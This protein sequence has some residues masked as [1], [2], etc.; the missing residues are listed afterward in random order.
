M[1]IPRDLGAR[2]L[3]QGLTRIGY[4]Q[5]RQTGSHIRLSKKAPVEHHVTIPNHDP[6]RIGTLNAILKDV[7]RKN[8]LDR[9]EL[10]RKILR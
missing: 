3:V 9:D 5:S 7:A 8:G 2:Q 10:L 4:E 1:K 6:I